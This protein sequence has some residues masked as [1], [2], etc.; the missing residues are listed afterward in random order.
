MNEWYLISDCWYVIF[1]NHN[2]IPF[3]RLYDE[4]L[5][6]VRSMNVSK[7]KYQEIVFFNLPASFTT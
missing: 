2:F 4:V 5:M 6:F 3:A 7:K 1:A